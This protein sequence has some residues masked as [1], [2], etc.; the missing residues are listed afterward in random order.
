LW[1]GGLLV[2]LLLAA[3]AVS[4][5]W[6]PW[7]PFDMAMSQRLQPPGWS[8]WLGTDA[9]GRDVASLLLL[10]ARASIAVGLVA[11]AI[12]LVIGSALGLLAAARRGWVE[13]LVMRLT[14][15]GLAFPAILTAIVLAAVYGPGIGNAMLAIGLYNVPSFARLARAG[16]SAV[17]SRDF[18]RAARALGQGNWAISI[19]HVLPNVMPL[20]VVQATVRFGI[21]ILAEAALSYLGLGTQPPQPSWGRL[22]AEAQTLMSQAPWLA[23]FPGC[24]IALAVLGVNLLGDGL[25]DRL[26][27]RRLQRGAL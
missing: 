3:A 9:Y 7:P 18:V 23:I 14:D 12:G 16:A 1:I 10:G 19:R 15:I 21:A 6:T 26:D 27:P 2:A 25:R 22:L 5:V 20:L 4:Y 8:H 24:A 11:V 17:W 13:S